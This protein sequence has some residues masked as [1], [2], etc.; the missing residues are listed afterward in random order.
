MKSNKRAELNTQHF[1]Y[2]SWSVIGVRFEPIDA[3]ETTL[4]S[5]Q[6]WSNSQ[7]NIQHNYTRERIKSS[8]RQF[9]Q[10]IAVR[11]MIIS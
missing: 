7:G 8:S 11:N 5:C 2:I 10:V 6:E 3:K 9:I 1:V 4:G